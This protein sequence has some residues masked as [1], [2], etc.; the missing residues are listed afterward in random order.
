[1]RLLAALIPSE[2][3]GDELLKAARALAAATAGLLGCAEPEKLEVST[4]CAVVSYST[5]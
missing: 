1:M 5:A 4:Q 2:P 3:T